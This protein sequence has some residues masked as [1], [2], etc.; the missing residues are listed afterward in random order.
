MSLNINV[1]L[2]QIQKIVKVQENSLILQ[3][4]FQNHINDIVKHQQCPLCSVELRFQLSEPFNNFNVT[5]KLADSVLEREEATRSLEHS[6]DDE[7]FATCRIAVWKKS[8]VVRLETEQATQITN[9]LTNLVETYWKSGM[10]DEKSSLRALQNLQDYNLID[11]TV[12]RFIEVY[13][14]LTCFFCDLDKFK[15]VNDQLGMQKGDEVIRHFAAILDL[16]TRDRAIPLHRSGDEFTIVYP[17]SGPEAAIDLGLE[18]LEKVRQ[19]DFGTGSVK[20]DVSA[21]VVVAARENAPTNYKQ[22]EQLAEKAVKLES[23]EKLRGRVNLRPS[24]NPIDF[25]ASDQR[26]KNLAM[27]IAKGN[28]DNLYPFESPWLNILSSRVHTIAKCEGFCWNDLASKVIAIIDGIGPEFRPGILRAC[29]HDQ[30][31][32]DS[33]PI[34]SPLDAAYATAH[35]IFSAALFIDSSL[36]SDKRLVIQHDGSEEAGCQLRL[37]PDDIIL[38][39]VGD[40][41]TL[42]DAVNL[43]EFYHFNDA[44]N[45]DP[46]AVRHALLVKVGHSQLQLPPSLF[47]DVLVVDDRPTR[48]GEL[49]DFWASILA[50]L[51]ARVASNPNIK[52]IY[53]VG[54]T[55][56]A[57]ETAKKLRQ[58]TSWSEDVEYISYKTGAQ[59]HEILETSERLQENVIFVEDQDDL[60][61]QFSDDLRSGGLLSSRQQ[62]MPSLNRR[63]FLKRELE[64]GNA[65]LSQHDGCRVGT[66]AEAFPIVVE[67]ARK[68]EDEDWILD[69]AGQELRELIDFKVHLTNPIYDRIPAFYHREQESLDQYLRRAF[70][71]EGSLFG[72]R[73]V[74]GGQLDGVLNHVVQTISGSERQ[75]ATRRAILIVSN[76][77]S[78]MEEV[79]PLGLVSVR[80]IPRFIGQK[81]ILHYSFTWRTVEVL[82]GFPYSLYGSIGYAEH[83][84]NQIRNA[85]DAAHSR[86]VEMGDVSYIAH[87][88]HIF[89]DDYG[90]NIARRI[91]DDASL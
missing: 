31:K 86:Q 47:T 49:P 18:I 72:S 40:I 65:A 1:W 37:L 77:S 12:R 59:A 3:T 19:Y 23:G 35:G 9:N 15:D 36:V 32:L 27:C 51:I 61:A 17:D 82:V 29:R 16:V 91:V 67:I 10:R 79:S 87:S 73:I 28:L 43:G 33:R 50:R 7:G 30:D 41:R 57:K 75:F 34:L 83:L 76:E 84:T 24:R 60:A 20:V 78:N 74:T 66:L 46:K 26:V 2:D 85:V 54:N 89:M 6:L 68:A 90:Q 81:I 44:D 22:L 13:G 38:L 56:Y 25:P 42:S 8:D 4:E 21:G 5:A 71:D 88:L 80:I 53:V 11:R 62:E 64:L 63:R 14:S 39:E 55:N 58:I 70:L 45:I 52:T 48:G 69:Q